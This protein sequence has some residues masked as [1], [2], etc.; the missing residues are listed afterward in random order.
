MFII[1]QKLANNPYQ[2]P[3]LYRIYIG[4]SL[5]WYNHVDLY[6]KLIKVCFLVKTL[7]IHC[8]KHMLRVVYCANFQSLLMYGTPHWYRTIQNKIFRLFEIQKWA[9]KIINTSEKH[10]SCRQSFKDLILL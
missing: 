7:P 5:P 8:S 10:I 4:N 1:F 2:K 9:L 3:I 6:S